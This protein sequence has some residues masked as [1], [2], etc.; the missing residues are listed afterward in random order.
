MAT[1]HT[2]PAI[3]LLL[4]A[5]HSPAASLTPAAE[6][7]FQ[8]Y[9]SKVETRL[10]SQ[11]AAASTYLAASSPVS[12]AE[13]LAGANFQIEPVN[14]GTWQVEAAL[15]H[16]WRATAFVPRAT[17][18]KMLTLLRDFGHLPAN[19]AP[20]VV[21]A[22]V[23]SQNGDAARVAMRIQQ[24]RVLT[25]V[26]D[27]EYA[28]ESKLDAPTRGYSI[29][30]SI[31]IRQIEQAGSPDERALDFGHDDG[32]LWHLNSYWSFQSATENSVEGVR[33]QCEAISLT[34]DIPRGLGWL[35]API[36]RDF[37][38]EALEFTMQSTIKALQSPASQK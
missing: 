35:I 30:R 20:Q 21:S 13:P 11:H 18:Q 29:S 12:S 26:L 34:R 24:D 14:G 36:I 5:P 19:Y 38:R 15:L 3:L 8:E 37:P 7:A 6:S 23:L 32:F 4:A 1:K 31:R 27:G 25:I 9:A 33:I 28:L 2:L 16:H 22:R 17:A 10:A